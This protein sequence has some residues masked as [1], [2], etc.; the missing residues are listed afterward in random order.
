MKIELLTKGINQEEVEYFLNKKL[1]KVIDKYEDNDLLF[2]KIITK[3]NTWVGWKIKLKNNR[4]VRYLLARI[5][6]EYNDMDYICTISKGDK[7][8]TNE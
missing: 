3:R 6:Y 8:I 1:S 7:N 4:N 5:T 2:E